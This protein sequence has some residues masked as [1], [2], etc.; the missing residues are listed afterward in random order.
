MD[1]KVNNCVQ[2][3]AGSTKSDSAKCDMYVEAFMDYFILAITPLYEK[4]EAIKHNAEKQYWIQTLAWV[5]LCWRK[6]CFCYDNSKLKPFDPH[7]E[8]K[9][10]RIELIAVWMHSKVGLSAG[11]L[12]SPSSYSMRHTH[13]ASES[14]KWALSGVPSTEGFPLRLACLGDVE[15]AKL[16]Y[17]LAE[18]LKKLEDNSINRILTSLDIWGHCKFSDEDPSA[19]NFTTLRFG[20]CCLSEVIAE[21]NNVRKNFA[22]MTTSHVRRS[23]MASISKPEYDDLGPVEKRAMMETLT[24]GCGS[25][26]DTVHRTIQR[27]KSRDPQPIVFGETPLILP[28]VKFI[29][30]FEKQAIEDIKEKLG[31]EVMKRLQMLPLMPPHLFDPSGVLKPPRVPVVDAAL[32][33]DSMLS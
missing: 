1:M 10:K 5:F 26:Q 13:G 8:L 20:L 22:N 6:H 9:F 16:S 12:S 4:D 29:T 27:N 31:A 17:E 25:G 32:R 18:V 11:L 33:K 15:N 30:D 3:F 23:L 19:V 7:F 14:R 28:K 21:C 2:G 24:T